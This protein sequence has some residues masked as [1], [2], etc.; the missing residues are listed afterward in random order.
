ML[1]KG[2][3]VAQ[4]FGVFAAEFETYIASLKGAVA[5]RGKG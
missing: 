2:D 5:D 3:T 4:G 1:L